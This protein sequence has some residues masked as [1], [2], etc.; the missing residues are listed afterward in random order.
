MWFKHRA[1]ISIAWALA[2]VNL[3]AILFV[4]RTG[5]GTWH[6]TIHAGLAVG[7]T[8][9]ARHLTVRR[10]TASNAAR[11]GD[12]QEQNEYLMESA[13]EMQDRVLELEERLDFAERLLVKHREAE[14]QEAPP[15]A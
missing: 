14:R 4:A 12:G 15:G 7:F 1:W 8:L 3:G 5:G 11:V 2:A 13:E 9:V 10:L 6:A